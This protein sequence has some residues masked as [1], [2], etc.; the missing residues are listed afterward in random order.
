MSKVEGLVLEPFYGLIRAKP[1]ANLQVERDQVFVLFYRSVGQPL[2]S[3]LS[4]WVCGDGHLLA[5]LILLV[6]VI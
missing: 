1:K 6:G 2:R 4:E 5:Q 3:A